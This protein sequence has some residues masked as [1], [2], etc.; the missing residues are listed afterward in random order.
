MVGIQLSYWDGLFS[1]A[2]LVL[3]RA[4]QSDEDDE[5]TV[6]EPDL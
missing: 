3:G 1:G 2:R 4:L 6:N 5:V